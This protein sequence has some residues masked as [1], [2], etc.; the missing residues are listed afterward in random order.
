M[1][2]KSI[3]DKLMN[4]ETGKELKGLGKYPAIINCLM[5]AVISVM[6]VMVFAFI[7]MMFKSG[8]DGRR[9]TFFGSLY[10]E[11]STLTN[12][13]VEIN[14]GLNNGVPI[15]I[16]IAIVALVYYFSFV[17]IGNKLVNKKEI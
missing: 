2:T 11:S 1:N 15:I 6:V 4:K 9:E 16:V 10:F 17:V 7:Q 12:G 8:E 5:G 3:S 14:M 13:D